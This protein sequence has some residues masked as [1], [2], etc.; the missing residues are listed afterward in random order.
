MLFNHIR[1]SLGIISETSLICLLSNHPSGPERATV[2]FFLTIDATC[3][4][5]YLHIQNCM[6]HTPL[7][8]VCF[9]KRNVFEIHSHCLI[10]S[11][12]FLFTVE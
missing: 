12:L 6:V 10:V 3:S 5:D 11:S 1:E 8:K 9:I 4:F 2:L 7:S